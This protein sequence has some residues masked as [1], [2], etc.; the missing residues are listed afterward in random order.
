MAMVRQPLLFGRLPAGTRRLLF[1]LALFGICF[2]FAFPVLWLILTSLRPESGVYYVHRG[3]GFTLGNFAEVL[4]DER[5]VQAFAN[6]ALI[7]TLATIFSLLVTVSSG[8]MLSRF[9]G[10]AARTWFGPIDGVRWLP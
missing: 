4:Q 10:P 9:S 6:S 3:T 1:A 7:A 2:L 8:Y 5:V